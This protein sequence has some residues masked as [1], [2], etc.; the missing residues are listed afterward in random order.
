M[1]PSDWKS[2]S[3]LRVLELWGT[4][5][6]LPGAKSDPSYDSVVAIVKV[7][8]GAVSKGNKPA[9]GAAPP[10]KGKKPS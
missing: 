3:A 7:L 9:K 5:V 8:N 10:T 4:Y 2:A 6:G 1:C